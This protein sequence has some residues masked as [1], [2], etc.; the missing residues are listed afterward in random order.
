M[1]K[2]DLA[3]GAPV[4]LYL[5]SPREKVFGLLVALETAGVI[6]RGLD[7]LSL[8]DWMRQEA[9]GET[10][11]LGLLSVFY[12]MWRLERMERDESVGELEGLA[13]RFHRLTGR[14]FVEEAGLGRRRKRA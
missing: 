14:R 1:K 10:S 6:V 5:H 13:D 8:E 9:R 12:P 4:L 2:L 3:P 11:G 7:L